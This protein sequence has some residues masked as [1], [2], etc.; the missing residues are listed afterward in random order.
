MKKHEKIIGIVEINDQGVL[1]VTDPLTNER[2]VWSFD[3]FTTKKDGVTLI[4]E[5]AL[6]ECEKRFRPYIGDK[7]LYAIKFIYGVAT[8][9]TNT[10]DTY[11]DAENAVE[12]FGYEHK[13]SNLYVKTPNDMAEIITINNA[14]KQDDTK[15]TLSAPTFELVC[16]Q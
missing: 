14:K 5:E 12:K 1:I 13:L 9:Y 4:S 6:N 16:N 8:H 7:R 15:A 10:Y 3:A 11:E 2:S